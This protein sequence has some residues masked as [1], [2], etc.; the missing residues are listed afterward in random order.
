[1]PVKNTHRKKW[2]TP[3]LVVLVK[4]MPMEGVLTD[5]RVSSGTVQ[6]AVVACATA[7]NCRITCSA[8]GGEL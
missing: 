8:G 7:L 3:Q 2:T 4:S 5:C 1:M 6:Y